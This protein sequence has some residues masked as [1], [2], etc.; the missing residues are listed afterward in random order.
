[1]TATAGNTQASVSWTAPAS[2]G[3]S[4][5]TGYTVTASPGGA[6]ASTTGATT[7]TVT[8]LTNGTAYTFTVKATNTV[9]TSPASAPSTAATPT[10]GGGTTLTD[11]F[12]GSSDS[13]A[14]TATSDGS[15]TRNVIGL[16]GN[17]DASV[18]YT[19]AGGTTATSLQ[20][21]DLHGNVA[22]TA[23]PAGTGLSATY[24][25]DEFGNPTT[26]NALRYSWLGGKDRAQ[27]GIG[28]LT[29]MGQRLYDPATGRFLQTDPIPGGSANA[30]DYA[31]QDPINRYD[32]NGQCWQM[33]KKKC[34][35]FIGK[36]VHF[37]AE[38]KKGILAG[39]GVAAG[40]IS[41]ASGL[42]ELAGAGFLAADLLDTL[43]TVSTVA[44]AV[45]SAA[46]APACFGGDARSCFGMA[47]NGV[48]FG[49]GALGSRLAE[50]APLASGLL[51]AKAISVGAGALAWDGVSGLPWQ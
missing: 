39:V 31:G 19:A 10:A 50:A 13:P 34:H 8:G 43:G 49:A 45:G 26:T 24:T 5:I 28:N 16:D 21:M 37:V 4:A 32:L 51:K 22:A 27:T 2:N 11:H 40:V 30:Y 18:A 7:A 48:G 44:A 36:S 33:W 9:G 46:D 23:N 38:H 29:L 42:G 35:K 17:N 1:M 14:W 6:T 25:Y 20:L 15:W 3:G 47:A 41:L 12:D